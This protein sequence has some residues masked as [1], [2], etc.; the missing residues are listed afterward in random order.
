MGSFSDPRGDMQWLHLASPSILNKK[1]RSRRALYRLQT[2]L[3][4]RAE[5]VRLN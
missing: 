4:T 1:A 2:Q 3:L 5:R